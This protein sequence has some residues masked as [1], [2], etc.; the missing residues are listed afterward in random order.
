MR[1]ASQHRREAVRSDRRWLVGWVAIFLATIGLMIGGVVLYRATG[2][3]PEIQT[4]LRRVKH[5]V[6][7]FIPF[8]KSK[9]N[10]RYSWADEFHPGVPRRSG[11]AEQRA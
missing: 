10:K 2:P 7:W 9:P 5:E 6:R 8:L 3:H 11:H 1:A 4:F